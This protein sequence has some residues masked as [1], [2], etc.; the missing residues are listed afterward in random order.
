MLPVT[1][2]GEVAPPIQA[3]FPAQWNAVCETPFIS[4][5]AAS[6]ASDWQA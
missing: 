6:A 3:W 5:A 4:T 1:I 2:V